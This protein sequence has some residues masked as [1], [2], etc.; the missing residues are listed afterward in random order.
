MLV[1]PEGGGD[2]ESDMTMI[3]DGHTT[4]E[5]S[6]PQTPLYKDVVTLFSKSKTAVHADAAG[7]LRRDL[8]RQVVPPAL[9]ALEGRAP[10]RHVTPQGVVDTLGRIRGIMATDAADWH[11]MDVAALAK[12]VM[13]AGGRVCLGGHGQMQGLGPHWEVWA[14]VQGG[15]IA[16]A[17][18]ARRHPL[19]GRVAGDRQGPGLAGGGQAG[20]LRGPREEPAGEDREQRDGRAGRQ[21]RNGLPPEVTSP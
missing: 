21:E 19:P 10:R 17:G 8:G 2:L 7:R 14:F 1:V 9:R 11:H 4:V 18:A 20:G 16:A 12:K 13:E 3:L 6:L 15:M 5:H